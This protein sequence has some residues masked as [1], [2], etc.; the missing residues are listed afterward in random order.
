MKKIA[1][2]AIALLTITG[3]SAFASNKGSDLTWY[4]TKVEAINHGLKEEGIKKEDIIGDVTENEETFIIFKKKLDDGIGVGVS[5]IG[6]KDGEF[7][8]YDADQDVLVKD[9]KVNKY[10]SQISWESKAF[11]GRT[12]TIYTG[13]SSDQR[14]LIKT[15]NGELSPT[16]DKNTGIYFHIESNK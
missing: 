9:E 6:E 15:S 13:M 3:C 10:A 8:W 12:V 7:T 16:V 11:S 5:N 1:P 2:F 4:N 14:P